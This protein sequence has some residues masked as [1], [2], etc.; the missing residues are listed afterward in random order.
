MSIHQDVRWVLT[1]GTSKASCL[2]PQVYKRYIDT[3]TSIC[4]R[5]MHEAG[6]D[7]RNPYYATHI[8]VVIA[9]LVDINNRQ[10]LDHIGSRRRRETN[11]NAMDAN[12][13]SLPESAPTP[14]SVEMQIVIG[15][16]LSKITSPPYTGEY[17]PACQPSSTTSPKSCISATTSSSLSTDITLC[18]ICGAV[19]KGRWSRTNMGRHKKSTHDNKARRPCTVPGCTAMLSRS[20]NLGKHMRTVHRQIREQC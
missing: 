6:P 4:D 12:M 14:I 3:I 19:F 20:D 5:V 13:Q 16:Q 17:S 7:W 2:S 15:R 8:D 10:H 1:S 11:V 18:P 9:S